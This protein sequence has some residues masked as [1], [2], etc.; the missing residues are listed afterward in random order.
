[1]PLNISPTQGLTIYLLKDKYTAVD[2]VIRANNQLVK[3]DLN[4]GN[5]LIGQ[6]FVEQRSPKPPRW[7]RFFRGF[8]EPSDLG[9]VST[10]SAVLFIESSTSNRLFAVTFGQGRHLLEDD[11]WEERFGLRVVLNSIGESNVRSIDKR[12]LDAIS[13]HSRE[14]ASREASASEF[15]IDIEQDLLR[16]ITGTPAE[17]DLGHRLSGMDAL[18]AAIP[19]NLESL[20]D[21]LCLYY[22]RYMDDTYKRTFPWVD[23]ISEI[24]S[25][26]LLSEL[27]D[28]VIAKMVTN[29]L[30]RIWM[31]VPDVLQ[32]ER[33]DGFRYGQGR[34][35]PRH[36]DIHLPGFLKT[37]VD[38]SFLT[39]E[40]LSHR[41]IYCVDNDGVLIECWPAYRCIYAEIEQGDETFL[42]SNGK[43]YR[44]TTD[45]V[46]E[47]NE[48]F[49]R[50]PRYRHNLPKYQDASETAYNLRAVES[51]PLRYA[52]MDRK[53]IQYGGGKSSQEFCDL[54]SKQKDIRLIS[55]VSG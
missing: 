34:T 24:R 16:A 36:H 22:D 26:A 20:R 14:Q 13:L 3:Y 42:L 53:N 46:H 49:R 48:A 55:Q 4:S 19:A 37:I 44:I 51:E 45:F 18:H 8:L 12:K 6:L 30:D 41:K 10:S 2:T 23:H 35:Y 11:S 25:N 1:M 38:L 7:A 33:V 27:D 43:W 28:A 47:V 31:A 17:S 29:D 9:L 50:L 15:E 32:W 54:F 40:I 52:L 5:A 21:L 39:K